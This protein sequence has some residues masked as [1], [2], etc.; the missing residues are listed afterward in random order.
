MQKPAHRCMDFA[1]APYAE[2][3]CGMNLPAPRRYGRRRSGRWPAESRNLE[4][5]RR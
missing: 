5:A 1:A 4:I 2:D 3:S